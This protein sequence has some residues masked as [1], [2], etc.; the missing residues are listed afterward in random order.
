[1]IPRPNVWRITKDGLGYEKGAYSIR[2]RINGKYYA[3]YKPWNINN[4]NACASRDIGTYKYL[5]DA[6]AACERHA[7]VIES[8]KGNLCPPA[9][10]PSPNSI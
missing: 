3:I 4:S 7:E 8:K 6:K 5:P 1:M 2:M 10:S 9:A